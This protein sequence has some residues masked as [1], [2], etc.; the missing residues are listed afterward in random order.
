[1]SRIGKKPIEIPAGINV[2]VDAGGIKV[3]GPKGELSWSCP[4]RVKIRQAEGKLFFDRADDTKPARALHG[5]ARSHVNNMVAGVSKG[6][7]KVLEIVGVGYKAQVQGRKIAFALGYSHPVEF[8]LPE[9]INAAV[10]PKQIILTLTGIDK[11]KLGQAAADIKALRKPDSYKGK[12][13]RYSGERLKLKA[14]KAG[15]K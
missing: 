10:D 13:I 4:D 3:K 9:G 8:E 11:Q 14:G 15:K 7:Q 2:E 1:M 12:G 5:L 6:Y